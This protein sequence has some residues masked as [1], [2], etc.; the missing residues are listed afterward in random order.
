MHACACCTCVQLESMH[1]ARSR[2]P[3]G[4]N[5]LRT[6]QDPDGW[7][8]IVYRFTPRCTSAEQRPKL[9]CLSRHLLRCAHAPCRIQIKLLS[10]AAVHHS[11]SVHSWTPAG[12]LQTALHNH[13]A[14]T[15]GTPA[16]MPWP[17]RT[18]SRPCHLHLSR[19]KHRHSFRSR[20]ACAAG[21]VCVHVGLTGL[22]AD[23]PAKST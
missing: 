4:L 1:T 18:C 20:Q 21:C 23:R 19:H 7:C 15:N 13:R 3:H 5:I 22:R 12:S 10:R 16:L 9:C 14:V 11:C 8:C 17:G 2:T 6:L